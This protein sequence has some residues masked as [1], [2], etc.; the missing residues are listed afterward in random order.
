MGFRPPLSGSPQKLRLPNSRHSKVFDIFSAEGRN[1]VWWFWDGEKGWK[2]GKITAVQRK[3]PI[4]G[5]WND[6]LVIENIESGRT[7]AND[8]R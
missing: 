1:Q 8:P 2:V 5:I 3:M 4:R 6:T 7:P